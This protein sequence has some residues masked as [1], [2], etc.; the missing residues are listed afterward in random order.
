MTDLGLM[1]FFL[2]LKIRKGETIYTKEILK[3]YKMAD[4]NPVSTLMEP[5]AKLSKFDGGERVNA[6]KYRSLVR[7]LRYL[8]CTRLDLSLS[9]DIV[10]RFMEESIY[11]HWKTLN[12]ILRYIRGTV[13][14]GLFYS[15]VEHYKL[16]GYFD[17]DWC[18]DLDD[19]KSTSGYVFFIGDT[20][21]TWLS[22]KQPIVTLMTCE[23]EYVTASWCVCHVIWLSNLLGKLEQQQLSAIVIRVDNKLAI[24]LE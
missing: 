17:S 1:K 14:L 6:R 24:E 15:N 21:F 18:G 20:T 12:R 10:S 23:A 11:S 19:R 8:T 4:C 22:K 13:S 9:V 5:G 16:V 7:S 2:G 3:K